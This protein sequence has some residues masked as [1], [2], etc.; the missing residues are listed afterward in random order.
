MRKQSPRPRALRGVGALGIATSLVAAG[1]AAAQ[2]APGGPTAEVADAHLAYG[3]RVVV[4]GTAPGG[5][6]APVRL[7]FLPAGESAWVPVAQAAAAGRGRFRLAGR[8]SRSGAVRVV[9]APAATAASAGA[10]AEATSPVRR[11]RVAAH[12]ATDREQIAV[13]V[14]RRALVTGTVRRPVAGRRVVLQRRAGSAW[15]TVAR[16][17][18]DARGA[19]RLRFTPEAADRAAL[20][21]RVAGDATNATARRRVGV[22]TAFRPAVASWYGPGFYGSTTACG[23]TFHAGL[24][25]VAHKSLPCGTEVTLRHGSRTVEATVVDRGPF[26]AGREFDLG[27]AVKQALGFGSGGTVEVAH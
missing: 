23:Q 20:R 19:F 5:A 17:R 18:T 21:L 4:S 11:V 14:G 16:D 12:V 7:E 25:G 1:P 15:A 22:L 26:V 10:G 13:R 3:E 8:L 27:V 24:M 2:D 6:G 9:A